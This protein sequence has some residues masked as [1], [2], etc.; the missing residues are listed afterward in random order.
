MATGKT[1]DSYNGLEHQKIILNEA[2]LNDAAV[3]LFIADHVFDE[4]VE[5][6]VVDGKIGCFTGP[7]GDGEQ[8]VMKL[9]DGRDVV[10]FVTPLSQ[11]SR[12]NYVFLIASAQHKKVSVHKT[13][14]WLG[15]KPRFPQAS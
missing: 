8:R 2:A 12:R 9:A 14:P 11:N 10:V 6:R 15:V 4:D 1:F 5:A 3:Q 7:A 13:F